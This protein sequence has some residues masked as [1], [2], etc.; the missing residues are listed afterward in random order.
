MF[1]D[2]FYTVGEIFEYDENELTTVNAK[3]VDCVAHTI[4][5][6]SIC[7]SFTCMPKSICNNCLGL[8]LSYAV[9]EST[10]LIVDI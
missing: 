10:L 5:L 3:V 6:Q 1:L 8:I 4:I 9:Q 7:I 2:R